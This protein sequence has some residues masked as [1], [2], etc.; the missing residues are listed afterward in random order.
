MA[1]LETEATSSGEE[2]R[3]PEELRKIDFSHGI[4]WRQNVTLT[5]AGE[6]PAF[7]E[8]SPALCHHVNAICGRARACTIHLPH[9][10]VETPVFMPVGTK[11][12]LK[13][14]VFEEINEDPSLQNQIILANTFHMELQPT[15]ALLKELGGLHKFMNWHGNL[16]TDSGGFQ[17][18]SLLKLAE[19]TEDG[20]TFES[21]FEKGKR[22]LLRPEDSILHQL[23]IGSDIIMALDDVV[24]SVADD[25]ERF[26]EATHR[27]LRW[28]DRCLSVHTQRDKQ[29]LFAIVQGG[30][31]T[32]LGGLREQCLAG[33]RNR[34]SEI[35]GYAIGECS[36]IF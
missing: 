24:S 16:L 26:R 8:E 28:L 34:D 7:T 4:S 27:T 10:P 12:T 13:G 31:D 33:F 11:G 20:V 17:M 23:N 9:G 36:H 29:N 5:P 22:L 35:P 19:I 1:A 3:M 15:T 14:V 32:S 6:S 18:V 2:E 25:K 21:P 30:L